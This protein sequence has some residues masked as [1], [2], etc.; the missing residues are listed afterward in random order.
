[1][2]INT[3]QFFSN[4]SLVMSGLFIPVF[5]K[6]LGASYFEVGLISALSSA[7]T[8]F[9]SFFSSKA[10]DMHRIRPIILTGL[11][12][13]SLSFFLQLFAYNSSSLTIIRIMTGCSVGIYPAALLVTVYY[14]KESIGKFSS[15]GALGWMVGYIIAGLTNNIRYLFIL[16]SFLYVVSFVIALKLSDIKKKPNASHYFSLVTFK[17]NFDVYICTFLRHMGAVS[18]WVIL[19][20]YLTEIGASRLWVSIIYSVNPFVQFIIM[21]RLERF[22]NMW[23]VKWGTFLSGLAFIEYY[24]SP[25]YYFIIFGMVL[26]AFGWSFLFVGANQLVVQRSIEKASSVGI[27]NSSLS[28]AE[29]TGSILGGFILQFFEF[30]ANMIFAVICAFLSMGIF[31][32]MNRNENSVK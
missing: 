17:K 25:N 9:S 27:L 3:I 14:E 30:K 1:M 6:S 4:A 11:A 21:R 2:R 29:I 13:S 10:A 5:A 31:M 12:I 20:L 19:P 24:I 7:A 32:W 16:S 23:L 26:V 18:V 28:A 15:F 22:T 8:F